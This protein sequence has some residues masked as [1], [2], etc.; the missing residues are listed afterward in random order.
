MSEINEAL[1]YFKKR[2]VYEKLFKVFKKKYESLGK[3]AGTAILTGLD[4]GEKLDLSDFL[5]KDFTEDK[6]VRVSV[7]LFEK[8][9]LKSKFSNLTT[10]NILTRYFGEELRT[11]KEKNEDDE[12]R[13]AEYLA[14]IKK[15]TDEVISNYIGFTL[16]NN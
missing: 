8:A 2:S 15:Y 13:K 4:R 1:E 6:E 11:K 3:I 5:M 12:I 14:E 10:E 16:S 7:K 9:L